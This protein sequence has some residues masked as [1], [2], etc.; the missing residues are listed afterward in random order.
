[1]IK[2]KIFLTNITKYRNYLHQPHMKYKKHI[3]ILY[4]TKLLPLFVINYKNGGNSIYG[5]KVKQ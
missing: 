2:D 5:I 3:N 1:M 4:E